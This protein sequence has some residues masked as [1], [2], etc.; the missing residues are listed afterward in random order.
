MCAFITP[1]QPHSCPFLHFLPV[2]QHP[3]VPRHWD[4][5]PLVPVWEEPPRPPEKI[6]VPC[7]GISRGQEGVREPILFDLLRGDRPR[8]RS[9]AQSQRDAVVSNGSAAHHLPVRED[10]GSPDKRVETLDL[11]VIEYLVD[12]PEKF[13]LYGTIVRRPE[14]PNCYL[15][16]LVV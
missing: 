3:V 8:T 14:L 7:P 11:L 16:S 2:I 4:L 12:A 9:V 10:T 5:P 6:F 1:L 15:S 13:W